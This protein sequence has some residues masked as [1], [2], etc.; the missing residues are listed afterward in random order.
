MSQYQR[1]I[2][3]TSGSTRRL[4][5]CPTLWRPHKS[6]ARCVTTTAASTTFCNPYDPNNRVTQLTYALLNFFILTAFFG[7]VDE[8]SFF[9]DFSCLQGLFWNLRFYNVFIP[10]PPFVPANLGHYLK[11]LG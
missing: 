3:M 1:S 4:P 5:I 8:K 9:I 2:P 11:N 10:D 6:P 7:T